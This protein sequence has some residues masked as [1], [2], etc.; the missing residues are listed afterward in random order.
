MIDLHDKKRAYRR[1][2]VQEYIVWRTLDEAIDWFVLENDEYV[3]LNADEQGTIRSRVFP[4][5]WLAV[6]A[7][8]EGDMKTVLSVLQTGLQASE[9]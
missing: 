4:G 8:L 7:L 2:G 9:G 6:S 3:L 5:L 1:S